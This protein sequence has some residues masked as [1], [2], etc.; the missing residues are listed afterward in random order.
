[1]F[2]AI[3]VEMIDYSVFGDGWLLCWELLVSWNG[4]ES[5]C[6]KIDSSNLSSELLQ[7]DHWISLLIFTSQSTKA[8]SGSKFKSSTNIFQ[9]DYLRLNLL[10]DS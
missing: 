3:F 2:S 8:A 9:R 5:L 1:M 10:L 6:L 7:A 4:I